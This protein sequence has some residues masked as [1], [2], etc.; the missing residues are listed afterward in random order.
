[1]QDAG[2]FSTLALDC[3]FPFTYPF[4]NHPS[5]I[6]LL[7]SPQSEQFEM[8]GNESL[9]CSLK[10]KFSCSNGKTK[11]EVDLP[12]IEM[13]VSFEQL[14]IMHSSFTKAQPAPRKRAFRQP[15]DLMKSVLDFQLMDEVGIEAVDAEIDFD[16][17]EPQIIQAELK[18]LHANQK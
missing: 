7:K 17:Q 12:L 16:D 1:M 3:S 10:T 4:L 14:K 6:F 18:Q 13:V 2:H 5:T 15:I 8:V 11:I 9:N